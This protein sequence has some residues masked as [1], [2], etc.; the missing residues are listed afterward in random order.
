MI[1]LFDLEKFSVFLR[2]A[3]H[4]QI[5]VRVLL[6]I[7]RPVRYDHDATRENPRPNPSDRHYTS[8]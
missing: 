3:S 1:D 6:C 8:S 5:F 4:L 7:F 2:F